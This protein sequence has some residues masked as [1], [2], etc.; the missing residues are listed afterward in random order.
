MWDR[1]LGEEA[2]ETCGGRN[3]RRRPTD[4]A[5]V[6]DDIL[7]SVEDIERCTCDQIV[8]LLR[9]ILNAIENDHHRC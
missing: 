9:R 6:L 3:R 7:E 4:V 5:G 2:E 1:V 8:P